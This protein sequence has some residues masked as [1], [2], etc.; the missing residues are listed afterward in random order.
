MSNEPN[1]VN[2]IDLVND[3]AAL[4]EKLSKSEIESIFFL[5]GYGLHGKFYLWLTFCLID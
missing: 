4:R 3:V 5:L 2:G 1:K